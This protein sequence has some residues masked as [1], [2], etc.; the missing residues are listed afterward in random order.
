MVGGLQLVKDNLSV[1]ILPDRF[2]CETCLFDQ[3]R[4]FELK[5][6]YQNFS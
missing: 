1:D 6:L 2:I 3:P 4:N 5:Y